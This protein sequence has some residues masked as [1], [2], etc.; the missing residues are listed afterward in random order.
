MEPA[1]T[2]APFD[3]ALLCLTLTIYCLPSW[4]SLRLVAKALLGLTDRIKEV[5]ITK[6]QQKQRLVFV[7]LKTEEDLTLF[8]SIH[9]AQFSGMHTDGCPATYHQTRT[10]VCPKV[11][12]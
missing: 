6:K 5:T 3:A 12:L 7:Q 4:V 2:F 9:W 1:I 10:R 8:K 11:F